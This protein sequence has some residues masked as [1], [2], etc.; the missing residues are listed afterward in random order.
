MH[1]N[2]RWNFHK[3]I[4][5]QKFFLTLPLSIFNF[6]SSFLS[7]FF[8]CYLMWFNRPVWSKSS[9]RSLKRGG[10]KEKFYCKSETCIIRIF[11]SKTKCNNFCSRF[12]FI[13]FFSLIH[14][15]PS[16]ASLK[17]W[18]FFSSIQLHY[19]CIQRVVKCIKNYSMS[20]KCE[21]FYIKK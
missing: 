1:D 16:S 17:V 10:K 15:S 4:Q 8:L 13:L 9:E 6:Y 19:Y 3:I 12:R 5:T 14:C 18:I 20:N 11:R 2:K 21:V 7:F